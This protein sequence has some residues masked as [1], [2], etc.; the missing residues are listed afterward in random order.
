MFISRDLSAVEQ[1]SH[2]IAVMYLGM[3]VG[4]ADR[5][6]MRQPE[7]PYTIAL[8]SSMLMAGPR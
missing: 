8:L 7:H 3:I 5:Q 6:V 1:V 4:W 2:R